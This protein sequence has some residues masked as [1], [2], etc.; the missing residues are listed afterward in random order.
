MIAHSSLAQAHNFYEDFGIKINEN[1][2]ICSTI[3]LVVLFEIGIV[4]D[5]VYFLIL[6]VCFLPRSSGAVKLG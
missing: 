6:L 3:W 2:F 4:K 1:T 5:I